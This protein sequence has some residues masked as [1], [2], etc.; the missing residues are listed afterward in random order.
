MAAT[1]VDRARIHQ[2]ERVEVPDEQF[3]AL[4]VCDRA[5][6]RRG[7]SRH[8]VSDKAT[9]IAAAIR[10]T[11]RSCSRGQASLRWSVQGHPESAVPLDPMWDVQQKGSAGP[12]QIR[13]I[14]LVGTARFE[15]ATP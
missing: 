15:L 4:A 6:R 1:L 14:R 10:R 5:R 8:K 9:A 11:S 3:S 13:L 7:L 2:P 12:S